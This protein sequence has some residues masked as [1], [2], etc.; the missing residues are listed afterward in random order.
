MIKQFKTI[1]G[2]KI[3][4][5]LSQ[6]IEVRETGNE[7]RYIAVFPMDYNQAYTIREFIGTEEEVQESVSASARGILPDSFVCKAKELVP[8]YGDNVYR[9]HSFKIT[10]IEY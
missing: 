2:K 8:E 9:V 3:W 4:L 6:A 7:G 5:D 10:D 1:E